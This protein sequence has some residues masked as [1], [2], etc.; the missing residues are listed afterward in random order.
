MFILIVIY[1]F[2]QIFPH[3]EDGFFTIFYEKSLFTFMVFC[4]K[5]KNPKTCFTNDTFLRVLL[6][7]CDNF[8]RL[9]IV[10]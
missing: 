4:P 6:V 10:K 5:L 8:I 9:L 2:E 1:L 3:K 7:H